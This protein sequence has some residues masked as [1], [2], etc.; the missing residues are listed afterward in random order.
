MS[1][2]SQRSL[3]EEIAW[4]RRV[5]EL[6]RDSLFAKEMGRFWFNLVKILAENHERLRVSI[7]SLHKNHERLIELVDSQWLKA[8][9]ATAQQATMLPGYCRWEHISKNLSDIVPSALLGLAPECHF[10]PG[11]FLLGRI[12]FA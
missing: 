5:E 9:A 12:A 2:L 7:V 1:K 6:G 8:Q 3:V 4:R 10:Y 11:M